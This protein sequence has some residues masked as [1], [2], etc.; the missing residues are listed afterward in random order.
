MN[1]AYHAHN[2]AVVNCN[3]CGKPL[4]P[5]CDHR[6][7]G[8]PFCQ[9]CIVS[10]VELLTN[11][12]TNQNY[13]PF[14]K[15]QSSPFIATILSMICPG[16][17]AVY[18]GQTSK[19]IT[20]FAAFVGLFQMAIF[21]GFPMFVLGFFG[22]WAYSA[23]DAWRTAKAIRSGVT[24]ENAEDVII[25]KITSNPKI[26]GS[27]LAFLG[28]ISLIYTLGFRLP[29]QGIVSIALIGLGIYF[30]RDYITSKKVSN[31]NSVNQPIPQNLAGGNMYETNFRTGDFSS[32]DE[33][34]TKNEVR[35]WKSS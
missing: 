19:A 27:V 32:F 11:R 8:F 23:L 25:Q 1:C 31:D 9:D 18:N 2:T 10:G 28:G 4:C 5:A 24:I 14:V 13:A 21:T 20:F 30:L 22:M 16:L 6:I 26:W 33:Y 34:K 7:K 35:N 17:G 15:R 29:M 3:G 12:S